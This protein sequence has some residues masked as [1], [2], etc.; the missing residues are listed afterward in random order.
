LPWREDYRE[1]FWIAAVFGF[2]STEPPE[3]DERP[4]AK[5]S[6]IIADAERFPI[7]IKKVKID[8]SSWRGPITP[9]NAVRGAVIVMRD[10]IGFKY[11]R[12]I[13]L[14]DYVSQKEAAQ[15]L[16]VPVM[17]VNRWVRRRSLKS[18]K[19]GGF[20]VVRLRDLLK[21]AKEQKKEVAIGGTILTVK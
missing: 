1:A 8:H 5:L 19:K 15:L 11:E 4:P 14:D 9:E 17:T 2:G 7:P 6:E 21:I 10:R 16:R 3:V 12:A 13:G 20:S 18:K